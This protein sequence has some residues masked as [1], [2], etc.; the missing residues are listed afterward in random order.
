M[1]NILEGC[2]IGTM[3]FTGVQHSLWEADGNYGMGR[4]VCLLGVF[5]DKLFS[6]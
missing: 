6:Y 1:L 3:L 2:E 5:L 4:N